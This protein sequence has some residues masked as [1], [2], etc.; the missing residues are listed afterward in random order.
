M[1]YY[2]HHLGDY[3]KDTV[4]LSMV[5]DGAYRRLIDVY[6]VKE[7]PLPAE[8][9]KV[10]KLARA[11]TKQE[12]DA[13][14]S[15]LDEFFFRSEDGW[16]HKR[17]DE[18]I[19]RYRISQEESEGKR[20]NEN[21]RQKRH[22]AERKEMFSTLRERGIVPAWDTTTA[23]LRA[24]I[25]S[26][27][28]G[29]PV[30]EPVTGAV[31]PP[32]TRTDT[33]NQSPVPSPQSPSLIPINLT[34]DPARPSAEAA[35]DL[36]GDEP[37]KPESGLPDCPH[38]AILG[39]WAEVMP[40]LPQHL[41]AKWKGARADH[42]RARWREEANERGWKLQAEGLEFF[43]RF[44]AWCRKSPFL[45]GKA[46]VRPGVRPFEFELEWLVN[47]SN[48]AKVHEGKYHPQG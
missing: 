36:L 13:V 32:V 17:C 15:I 40:D 48:W 10:F 44:L 7:L 29:T 3:A 28:T 25:E 18:E 4:H 35:V 33:A 9:M 37:P 45:M 43:R 26:G 12:K 14:R 2:E 30:T 21:E 11:S 27:K 5:E 20:E 24:L 41:P 1:N 6:Y 16:H 23:A 47:P 34:V 39:V 22:R 42:L 46:A 38:L 31:T 19:E 8:E